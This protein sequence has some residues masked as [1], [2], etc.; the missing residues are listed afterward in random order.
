M[1][2]FFTS[3]LFVLALGVSAQQSQL[4]KN[5]EKAG[6]ATTSPCQAATWYK[7]AYDQFKT[8]DKLL[9]KYASAAYK[10][11]DYNKVIAAVDINNKNAEALRLLGLSV[12]KNHLKYNSTDSEGLQKKLLEAKTILEKAAKLGLNTEKDY[13][14]LEQLLKES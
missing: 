2:I 5:N 14:E 1:K 8:S 10:C 3:L 7:M 4:S 11:G 13:G 9:V 6:D 12:F